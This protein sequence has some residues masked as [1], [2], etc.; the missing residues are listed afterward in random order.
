LSI[1]NQTTMYPFVF[2]RILFQSAQ[3]AAAALG[4]LGVLGGFHPSVYSVLSVLK[5]FHA[6]SD[7]FA[8]E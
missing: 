2:L 1:Y 7:V 8:V 3:R 5:T 4:V 6:S